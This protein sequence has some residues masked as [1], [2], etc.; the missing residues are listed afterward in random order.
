M[1]AGPLD[2]FVTLQR[3]SESYSDSGEPIEVWADV[4]SRW[5]ASV[6][7]IPGDERFAGE[8]WIARQQVEFR[9]RW[10]QE[11]SDLSPLDRVIYPAPGLDETEGNPVESTVYDIMDVSEIG[12][13]E[14]LLIKAARRPDV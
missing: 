13:R 8:Q 3:K 1:R 11:V 10:A 9:T 5:Y 6:R 4:V 12:R 14:G 2:R 7:P